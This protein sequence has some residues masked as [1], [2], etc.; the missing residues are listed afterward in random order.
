MW[1]GPSGEPPH[2]EWPAGP[3]SQTLMGVGIHPL[4]GWAL[5]PIRV[6]RTIWGG[7]AGMGLV[8]YCLA[9]KRGSPPPPINIGAPSPSKDTQSQSNLSLSLTFGS[10]ILGLLMGLGVSPPYARCRAAGASVRAVHL[11]LLPL[12]RSWGIVATSYVCRTTEVLHLRHS[13]PVRLHN[14]E[15]GVVQLHRQRSLERNAFGLQGYDHRS[16]RY[17]ISAY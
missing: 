3:K 2:G 1:G 10:G 16:L 5:G 11:P 15:V 13:S 7:R 17:F 14:L 6:G 9:T 12:D 4:A 8:P